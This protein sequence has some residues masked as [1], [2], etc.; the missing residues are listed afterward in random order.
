M[1]INEQ[2]EEIKELLL[3]H[4]NKMLEDKSE[5]ATLYTK[6]FRTRR[7]YD[8]KGHE[9]SYEEN[10]FDSLYDINV[11]YMKRQIAFV[12][13]I[14]NMSLIGKN[15]ISM[16]ME[17]LLLECIERMNNEFHQNTEP[18]DIYLYDISWHTEYP[19]EYVAIFLLEKFAN[20]QGN[21]VLIG[22][23]GSGKSSLVKTLKGNDR[24]NISVIPAQKTLYFSLNDMNMLAT[25][26]K[27]L[28]MVLLENNIDRSKSNDD[29]DY[30]QF[31]NRQF[32]KLIVAMKKQY[33]EYLIS[34]EENGIMAEKDKTIFGKMRDVFAMIFPDIKLYF[35]EETDEYLL[36]EK[37]ES[38]YP[39]NGLSEGEKAVIYYAA[40][41]MMAKENSFIV[42]DEPETYLNPSLTNILWDILLKQ[43]KDCQ[44]I[45]ITHSI[46]FVL[47]R[48]FEK[49]AWI[50]KF[51]YPETWDFDFV[52]NSFELPKTLMT[53]VLGSKKPIA[54]CEGDD[55]SSL[56]YQ[57]YR[58]ILEDKY[59]VIP[60]GGHLEVI[61]NCDVINQSK[62][63]SQESIGIIDGDNFSDEKIQKLREKNVYV[64]PFNEIEMF[65]VSEEI[66][67]HMMECVYPTEKEKRIETFKEK[68]WE[69]IK[70]EKESVALTS[71]K[72]A[73]DEHIQ[74]QKIEQYDSVEHIEDNLKNIAGYNVQE[75]Y[76]NKLNNIEQI[77]KEKD[78][79]RLLIVCNLKKEITKGTAN[80]QLD[81]NYEEKVVQQI[82]ASQRLKETLQK[83]YFEFANNDQM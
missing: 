66:M 27:D 41:V 42:V 16:Q 73:V 38:F 67:E 80:V 9:H 47:G 21:I 34:C 22:G 31:Q 54:F 13:K 11:E 35:R 28:E 59:T 58:A 63:L 68:F 1:D 46:D 55:K 2:L 33:T 6:T 82:M 20:V 74:K 69:I 51:E 8:E 45:F 5:L 60:V 26:A 61:K 18:E 19:R 4:L 75:T 76:K 40:N 3:T 64:L 37:A 79:R 32:T 70:K 57:V 15:K 25:K 49:I 52:D 50:K 71:T 17:S 48:N 62:W 7:W 10:G 83:V 36:C 44:F 24:E 43:R 29:Y 72:Q 39:V 78:Y 12:E 30:F 53:E 77:I 65:L 56:D 81:A 14:Q 23:N